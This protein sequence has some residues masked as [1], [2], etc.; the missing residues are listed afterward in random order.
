MDALYSLLPKEESNIALLFNSDS[1]QKKLHM[2]TLRSILQG[3]GEA[4]FLLNG[5]SKK[6]SHSHTVLCRISEESGQFFFYDSKSSYLFIYREK[7][8]LIE[9][10]TRYIQLSM[11]YAFKPEGVLVL[12]NYSTC[13]A[14]YL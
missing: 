10:F 14:S 7:E 1:A 8:T 2:R 6:K 4:A 5:S 13:E 11:P 12:E 3:E 9:E